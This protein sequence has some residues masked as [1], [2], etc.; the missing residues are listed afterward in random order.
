MTASQP[1]SAAAG[2]QTVD[3]PEAVG[4]LSATDLAVVSSLPLLLGLSWGLPEG[5]WPRL[6]AAVA[7]LAVRMHTGD[8]AAAVETI[9]RSLGGRDLGTP[10]ARI[11]AQLSGEQILAILQL[12]RTY[13]PGGWSPS[14]RLTGWQHVEAAQARGR[15]LILWVGKTVYGDLVAKIACYRAGLAVSHLSRAS[16]G[17]SSSRFGVRV[18]NPIHTA[19]EDRY[20]R[21]RVSLTV[22]GGRA[23]MQILANRLSGGGAVSI[24]VHSNTK[25]PVTAP[26][27][28]GQVVL[29]PG[30][31]VLARRTGAAL[32]PVFAFR[33]PSDGLTLTIEAPLEVP[34]REDS[35]A[36]AVAQY[37]ERLTPYVLKYPGQWSGWFHL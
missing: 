15:G 12:L 25:R 36:V 30:A 29:S 16:H 17:F 24:A 10:L 19:V 21:E 20:L 4:M 1:N 34:D 7:P 11:L 3:P 26:F 9:R 27:L 22:H 28:E 33:D 32:L 6:C 23:A 37:A 8:P 31:P 5:A 2:G 14:I 13:R 18:L 35:A